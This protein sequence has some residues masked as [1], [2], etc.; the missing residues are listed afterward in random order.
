MNL[1]KNQVAL[2]TG[3]SS[4]IGKAIAIKFAE[5]GARL[6]LFGTN[7]ERGEAVVKEIQEALEGS[8][9]RF[10]QVDVGNHEAVK[11]AVQE[12]LLSYGNVDILVNN[13]GITRDQLIMRMTEED[14][15]SVMAVNVKSCYNLC[16]ALVR[17][18]M[19]A[20]RGKIINVSSV[21]GLTGNSAQ[22][23]YAASKAAVIGFTKALAKELSSRQINVNCLAPGF[24]VTKMTDVLT[25]TQKEQ[26]LNRIPLARFGVPEEIA[27]VAL[28]LA[29]RLSDYM[30]GQ[31]ISV[32]GGLGIN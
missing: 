7:L 21:V 17:S 23:N 1:L 27:N 25:E 2:I 28:F 29:S 16:H 31:V 24:I 15:D 20:K 22:T 19:K 26:L 13:A 14:W 30:T 8:H 32:D 9:V 3:G 6:I 5:S 18:M 10:Y 11:K 12:I 4:G